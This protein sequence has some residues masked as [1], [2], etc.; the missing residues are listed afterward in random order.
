MSD[1]EKVTAYMK[2]LKHPFKKEIEAV[3]E[4]IKGSNKKLNE[5][6]KW[7][8]PSYYYKHDLVTFNCRPAKFVLLVFHHPAIVDI[9]SKLLEG[10]YKDRRLTYFYSMEEIEKNKKELVKIINALIK[11]IDNEK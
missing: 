6:I 10:E 2:Q 4:I 11:T 5:R 7:N 1:E 8:A 9:P 3:R